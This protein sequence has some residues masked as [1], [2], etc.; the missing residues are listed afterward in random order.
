MSESPCGRCSRSVV[1][2]RCWFHTDFWNELGG[3]GNQDLHFAACKFCD[4]LSDGIFSSVKLITVRK[5]HEEKHNVV[6]G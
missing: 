4:L 1:M 3:K 6:V 2:Y 5:M